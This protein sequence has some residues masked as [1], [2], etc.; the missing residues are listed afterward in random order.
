MRGLVNPPFQPLIFPAIYPSYPI[1]P[2][3]QPMPQIKQAKSSSALVVRDG[4]LII[5]DEERFAP[6]WLK[7]GLIEA[8]SD[9]CPGA[10]PSRPHLEADGCYVTPG[11]I[12]LQVNGGPECD[13]WAD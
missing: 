8:I 7:D 2:E 11:L 10:D 13:L 1:E 6:I 9:C 5:P 12:D 3:I 4:T